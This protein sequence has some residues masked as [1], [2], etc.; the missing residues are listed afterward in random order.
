MNY[1]KHYDLLI[2]RSKNRVLE[3]YVEKHHIIPKCLG[4][5]DA[6][7]NLAILTPEEHFLAHQ[8]LIKLNPGHRGL[9]YAVQMMTNHHTNARTN[10]KLFGWIRKRMALA[11]SEQTRNW[12]KEHKHPRGML[13][14]KHTAEKKEQIA[15]SSKA[16][17]IADRGVPVYTYNLDGTFCKSYITLTECA[18]DLQTNPSNVKYTA[19][20][21]FGHCKGKQIRYELYDQIEPY[22]RVKV[23]TYI[24][25][26]EH[27]K[28]VGERTKNNKAV[29]NHCGM[30]T[31]K[32]NIRRWHNDN[33]KYKMNTPI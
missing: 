4:G 22:V 7:E 15:A 26:D 23:K 31:T 9:I 29:C 27:K 10:N 21:N 17:I 6:K 28:C 24:R 5:T 14:K 33:C 18:D 32:V 13:G 1:K 3:G 11:M 20:G 30:E 25:T 8:L 2:E 12:L 19:D 16:A